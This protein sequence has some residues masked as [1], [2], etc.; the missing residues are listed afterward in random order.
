MS[1]DQELRAIFQIHAIPEQ[2]QNELRELFKK[3][4]RDGFQEGWREGHEDGF[5][6]LSTSESLNFHK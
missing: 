5:T 6:K 1:H 4:N 3:S 2:A